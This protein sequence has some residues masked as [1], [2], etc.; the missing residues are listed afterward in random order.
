M[1]TKFTMLSHSLPL[2]PIAAQPHSQGTRLMA[3]GGISFY[4]CSHLNLRQRWWGQWGCTPHTTPACCV[5]VVRER[6]GGREKEGRREGGWREREGGEMKEGGREG[7]GGRER[8]D[9]VYLVCPL[10]PLIQPER[11][12]SGAQC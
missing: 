10:D 5:P 9:I 6:G 11:T 8:H 2:V 1:Y 12:Q 4:L 7:E 3:T